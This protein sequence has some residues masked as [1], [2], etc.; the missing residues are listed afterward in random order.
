MNFRS[1]ELNLKFVV[2]TRAPLIGAPVK[3]N[4]VPCMPNCPIAYLLPSSASHASQE[5]PQV[6]K[7]AFAYACFQ[8]VDDFP[9]FSTPYNPVSLSLSL[10]LFLIYDIYFHVTISISECEEY[11]R[12]INICFYIYP[13]ILSLPVLLCFYHTRARR[14]RPPCDGDDNNRESMLFFEMF[15][16]SVTSAYYKVETSVFCRSVK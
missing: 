8:F 4:M 7:Q 14:D 12:W 13:S 2:R 9:L 10:C 11:F 6:P 16:F 3:S 1:I 5:H 15:P